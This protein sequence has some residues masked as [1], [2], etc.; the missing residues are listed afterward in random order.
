[1]AAH[2]ATAL[3]AFA[4]IAENAAL[5]ATTDFRYLND[6]LC[7]CFQGVWATRCRSRGLSILPMGFFGSAA[8]AATGLKPVRFDGGDISPPDGLGHQ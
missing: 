4:G 5:W 3:K 2:T 8:A 1:L 7:D 6:S